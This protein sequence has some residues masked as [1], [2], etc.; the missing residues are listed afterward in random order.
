MQFPQRAA[1]KREY[2][3]RGV[4]SEDQGRGY[5][6]ADNVQFAIGQGLLSATPIQLAT[7]YAALANGGQVLQPRVLKAIWEPGV[8]DLTSGLADLSAAALIG[9]QPT[10]TVIRDVPMGDWI[11]QPI[12]RGLR[13]VVAGPGANGYS[14]TAQGLFSHYPRSA[15]QIAGKT[16][17]AQ[18]AGNYPW[19]DSSVFVGFAVDTGTLGADIENPYVVAAYLEK[20]GFG[21]QAAGPVVKC[22]FMALSDK[23]TL[24]PV[25][26]SD[27]LD[28][29]ATVA[30][31]EM[32]MPSTA[33]WDGR[34]GSAVVRSFG[35]GPN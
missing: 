29:D 33:C 14:T 27:P 6:V 7:G 30:A 17:T 12:V 21:A 34:N 35:G 16:G 8:P 9:D 31:P 5:F 20:A 26:V 1:L 4:I 23:V 25:E 2:A 19:N 10:T 18:G 15:I 32:T 3:R 22:V 28:L 13:R 11:R 24:D